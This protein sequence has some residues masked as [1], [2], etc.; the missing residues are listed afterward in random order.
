MCGDGT[1]QDRLADAPIEK[2]KNPNEVLQVDVQPKNHRSTNDDLSN[3]IQEQI[4]NASGKCNGT[5]FRPVG[6]ELRNL[7][8]RNDKGTAFI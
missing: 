3:G 1:L 2:A 7:Q 4:H 6:S 8:K 5:L